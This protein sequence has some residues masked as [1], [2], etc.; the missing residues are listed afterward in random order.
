MLLPGEDLQIVTD[1]LDRKLSSEMNVLSVVSIVKLQ[2]TWHPS[3]STV[4]KP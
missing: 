1:K 4:P 3:Y 2:Q